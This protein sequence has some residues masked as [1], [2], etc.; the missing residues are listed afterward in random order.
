MQSVDEEHESV[1]LTSAVFYSASP[2]QEIMNT[3]RKCDGC[4]DRAILT[5]SASKD[6]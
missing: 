1:T 5:A 2:R 6:G 3:Q 4:W